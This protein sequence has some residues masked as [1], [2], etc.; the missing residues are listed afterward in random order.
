[1]SFHHD[2]GGALLDS[3][4]GVV[5][6]AISAASVLLA[7][8]MYTR[9]LVLAPVWQLHPG[10]PSRAQFFIFSTP[11]GPFHALQVSVHRREPGRSVARGVRGFLRSAD[12]HPVSV[13]TAIG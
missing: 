11:A 3:A 6:Y 10:C 9:R 12:H 13:R 7:V 1:M 8:C 2:I 4:S 5:R